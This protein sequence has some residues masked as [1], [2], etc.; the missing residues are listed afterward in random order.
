MAAKMIIALSK[1]LIAKN[2]GTEFY[3]FAK[4]LCEEVFMKFAAECQ[5]VF[6]IKTQSAGDIYKE[7]EARPFE[8]VWEMIPSYNL[9]NDIL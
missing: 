2:Y 3:E 6:S 8:H 9:M 5:S 4:E 1:E 7:A